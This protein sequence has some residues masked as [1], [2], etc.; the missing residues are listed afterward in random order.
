MDDSTPKYLDSSSTNLLAPLEPSVTSPVTLKVLL[1]VLTYCE[2][3][4][5]IANEQIG[6]DVA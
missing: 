1:S 4:V 5:G 6:T 3:D 2:S